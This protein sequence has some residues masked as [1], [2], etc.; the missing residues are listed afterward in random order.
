MI[1]PSTG[2]E[3]LTDAQAVAVLKRLAGNCSSGASHDRGFSGGSCFACSALAHAFQAI[4]DRE[5]LVGA[6]A[7]AAVS[8]SVQTQYD[9]ALRHMRGEP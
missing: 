9:A 3:I 4:T 1:D 6:C 8:G 5:A 2:N 7:I